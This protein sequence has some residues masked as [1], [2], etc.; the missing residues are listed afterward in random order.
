MVWAILG[1]SVISGIFYRLG[2]CGKR[3]KWYDFMCVTQTRDAGCS[4]LTT[5]ALNLWVPHIPWWASAIHFGL[6]WGFLTTYW[7][8]L[9]DDKEVWWT[10]VIT[11]L[12]YGLA[13]LSCLSSVGLWVV[14]LRAGALG[15]GTMLWRVVRPSIA[16]LIG[17]DVLDEFGVGFM[18]TASV[19]ML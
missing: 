3:G 18:L 13:A 15:V 1:L 14:L 6:L 4:L 2:G 8:F 12:F 5:V 16:G 9:N 17:D 7:D 19:M 10:W 11:G